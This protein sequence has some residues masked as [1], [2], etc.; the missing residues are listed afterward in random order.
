MFSNYLKL[1]SFVSI[2]LILFVGSIN[3]IIDPLWYGKGNKLNGINM[4]FNERLTKTNLYLKN[5]N[6]YDCL[7]FGSSRTTLLNAS[8]LKNNNCF[9]YSF[10][11]G[12]IAEFVKYAEYVKKKGANPKKIYIGVDAFNFDATKTE[13]DIT[14]SEPKPI[15]ESYLFSLDT[16]WLST[17]T[18]LNH[19]KDFI[20]F[21]D[22]KF[23]VKV[24]ADA[25]KY[26]PKLIKNRS[27]N[28][29][30]C[31][32]ESISDYKKLKKIFPHAEFIAYV[33]PI[34][35][36]KFYNEIY[37]TGLFNCKL[38]GIYQ[39]SQL[40]DTMYD[41][42]YVSPVTTNIDNT[43]DGSHFYP[44]I[45]DKIAEI[46]EGNKS[47]FGIRVDKLSLDYYQKFHQ[48]KLKLFLENQGQEKLWKG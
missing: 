27:Q 34:S 7:I 20:R 47:S 44:K 14:I 8:S 41:F 12:R 24:F 28:K 21:Y 15:Y 2:F 45:N 5:R 10:S 42:S 4:P 25:P 9:N 33:P 19:K 18:I 46:I 13:Y 16:F 38:E 17:K 3:Y 37:S 22:D 23:K 32:L 48:K 29:Y 39:V 43:Y 11:A 6:K 35:A 31:N 40:F 1:Y 26:Q 30:N 36:W